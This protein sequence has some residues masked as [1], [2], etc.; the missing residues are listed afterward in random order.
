VK[1][2]PSDSKGEFIKTVSL[3]STMGPGVRLLIREN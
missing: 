2:R 1:R 3:S